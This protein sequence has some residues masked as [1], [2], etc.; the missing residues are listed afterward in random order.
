MN[1]KWLLISILGLI[2]LVAIV[3]C[4]QST[5]APELESLTDEEVEELIVD[6]CRV[7]SIQPSF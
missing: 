1:K 3:A 7:P 6:K 4:S 5:P 2:L